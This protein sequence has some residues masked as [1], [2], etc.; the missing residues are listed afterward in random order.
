MAA[1]PELAAWWLAHMRT[2]LGRPRQG[3]DQI[4]AGPPPDGTSRLFDDQAD[5]PA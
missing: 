4:L 5:R 3:D 1:N 2:Q